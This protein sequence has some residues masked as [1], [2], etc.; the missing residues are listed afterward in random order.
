MRTKALFMLGIT[1]LCAST[2]Q[3]SGQQKGERRLGAGPAGPDPAQTF[4]TLCSQDRK[5]SGTGSR[6]RICFLL[7]PNR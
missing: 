6:H 5:D 7:R 1:F 4:D 3:T 2:A